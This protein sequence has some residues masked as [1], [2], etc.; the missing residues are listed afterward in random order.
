ML[1]CDHCDTLVTPQEDRRRCGE[2]GK[3]R[4]RKSVLGCASADTTAIRH[5]AAHPRAAVH[6]GAPQDAPPADGAVL[7]EVLAARKRL[8]ENKQDDDVSISG[9][10]VKFRR[11]SDDKISSGK[12]FGDVTVWCRLRT[13]VPK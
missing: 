7:D 3:Y 9:W 8:I 10:K 1:R 4:I 5:Q 6:Q 13:S 12:K 2:C 11:H